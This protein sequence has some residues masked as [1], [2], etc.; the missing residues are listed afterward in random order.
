MALI[1]RTIA[2]TLLS[3]MVAIPLI[4]LSQIGDA[5][6]EEASSTRL[7]EM[8]K[9]DLMNTGVS[10]DGVHGWSEFVV[11]RVNKTTTIT[12]RL[13]NTGEIPLED[14]EITC[15]I[16][17]YDGFY[18]DRGEVMFKDI[19]LVDVPPGDNQ[20]SEIVDFKWV[21]SF[22]GSYMINISAHVPGDARP[23]STEPLFFQGL[24][25]EPI[26]GSY[27]YSGVWVASE[28]W[29]GS[30]FRGWESESIG[31]PSEEG[32]DSVQH[33][34]ASGGV[35]HHSPPYCFWA[36]N[37]TTW[38]TSDS[39][40]HSLISPEIDLSR[41][42]PEPY[43][44]ERSIRRPQIFLLYRYRG[45]LTSAGPDGNGSLAH[46][47]SMD[48]GTTWD[49]L[50]NT[51]DKQV[52]ITGNTTHSRWDYSKRP[53]YAGQ[54]HMVGLDLG[55]YQ[56]KKI[57]LKF[58]E[59]LSGL[60]ETGYLLDD[61][62]IMGMDLV[63]SIPFDLGNPLP[64]G[65]NVDPGTVLKI[66]FNITPRR[67]SG[68]FSVRFQALNAS[69]MISEDENVQIEPDQITLGG[70]DIKP[71]TITVEITIPANERSGPGWVEIRALGGGITR[72]LILDFKVNPRHNLL[73]SLK[74]KVNG[75]LEPFQ[76]V[77][78]DLAIENAGNI[79]ERVE[80]AYVSDSDMTWSGGRGKVQLEP[81]ESL[82]IEGELE[83]SNDTMSGRKIGFMVVSINAIPDDVE[84]LESLRSGNPDQ[85]WIIHEVNFTVE[86]FYSIE[87]R[88]IT[89]Y[90]DVEDPP[91]NGSVELE[92]NLF[93]I[94]H[95][96][97]PDRVTF[98]IDGFDD[99]EGIDVYIPPEILLQSESS[100]ILT[101]KVSLE[102]PLPRGQYNLSVTAISSD[103]DARQDNTAEMILLIGST[104]ISSG[105]Y[106]VNGSLSVQKEE[107]IM[108]METIIEFSSLTFG[109]PKAENFEVG[110]LID[111]V[112]VKSESFPHSIGEDSK[113]QMTWIFEKPGSHNLTIILHGEEYPDVRDQ[114]LLS[115]IS[116][117]VDILYVDLS[118][119]E[120]LVSDIPLHAEGNRMDPGTYQ[121]KAIILNNGNASANVFSVTLEIIELDEP[122]NR[123]IFTVNVTDIESGSNTTVQFRSFNFKP[124]RDYRV[125]ATID[126]KDKWKE[127]SIENDQLTF[128]FEVGEVPPTEPL[129]KTSWF[130]LIGGLVA[131]MLSFFIFL[132]LMRKK[133]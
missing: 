74:G 2:V 15:T 48:N 132:Y 50:L 104:P 4:G 33:P 96:N 25:Y 51:K 56:G 98:E 32:W 57:R 89:T 17:W 26:P 122:T 3:L 76:P 16:Y 75:I 90:R 85:S 87:L 115:R 127:G 116:T 68:Q 52:I 41:F 83:I 86:Q 38:N 24:K 80:Y 97:G 126:V 13:E 12:T 124:E 36:G 61:I 88:A 106:L 7:S 54:G 67:T 69:G 110:F 58:E 19:V 78:T 43:D 120:I 6:K 20:F 9:F 27:F 133:L 119:E 40:I 117:T 77:E 125:T 93:L 34:L 62:T 82:E 21:P 64:L 10:S 123:T 118:V 60:D 108:G 84:I 35:S 53:F 113:H 112:E 47:I 91:S 65:K 8:V 100:E 101:A 46:Y 111:E 92:Y 94:N 70:E 121:F 23:M 103:D 42:D 107:I 11:G 114:G 18:P 129:W 128:I 1:P 81:G 102:F 22:S 55:A 99:I 63:E 72:D 95:G 131:M 28:Y 130:P 66:S 49:P 39:G 105:T 73:T 45:N 79:L 71:I 59:S 37:T 14:V 31:A 109:A 5:D 44:V 29:D 30:D